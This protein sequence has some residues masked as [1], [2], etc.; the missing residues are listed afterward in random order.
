LRE[1]RDHWK[2]R[3]KEILAQAIGSS[4][5]RVRDWLVQHAVA[6]TVELVLPRLPDY[7]GNRF[8]QH[9]GLSEALET[10]PSLIGRDSLFGIGFGHGDTRVDGFMLQASFDPAQ[11]DV[12]Q[13]A[14]AV[15]VLRGVGE[16][17]SQPP[18]ILLVRSAPGKELK[19][20]DL[21]PVWKALGE[22]EGVDVK[23]SRSLISGHII[24]VVLK[25]DGK[26]RLHDIRAA[27]KLVLPMKPPDE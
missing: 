26:A 25:A 4:D 3:T 11:A 9:E 23:R 1:D 7:R 18:A 17:R 13:I 8:E 2:R 21:E 12:G 15:D 27:V 6:E 16:L 20:A 10:V 24:G 14:K 19:A 5:P 22:V